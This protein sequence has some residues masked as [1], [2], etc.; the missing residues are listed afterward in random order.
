[1]RSRYFVCYDVSDDQR[2]TRTHKKMLGYGDPVQYSV[3]MCELSEKELVHLQDD[4][5]QI[6]NLNEDR[7]LVINVGSADR[8]VGEQVMTMGVPL[9]SRERTV[10]I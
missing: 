10:V 2:L 5:G 7:L 1:M 4:L 9:G 8:E 6:L 3:F